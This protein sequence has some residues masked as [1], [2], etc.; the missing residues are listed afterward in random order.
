MDYQKE[1]RFE[2]EFIKNIIDK[3]KSYNFTF[4]NFNK[5]NNYKQLNN[6]DFKFLDIDSNDEINVDEFNEQIIK[7]FGEIKLNDLKLLEKK[8]KS[9]IFDFKIYDLNNDGLIT[10][11]EL[12]ESDFSKK[13]RNDDKVSYNDMKYVKNKDIFNS[14][15]YENCF[16]GICKPT[17]NIINIYLFIRYLVEVE[18]VVIYIN[19][20]EK[21]E[22]ENAIFNNIC[23]KKNICAYH[24]LPIK[25]YNP[26][27]MDILKKF[28]DIIE[29]SIT[30][31]LNVIAH[32]DAGMGRT[33]FMMLCYLIYSEIKKDINLK[34]IYLNEID[35]YLDYI[36]QINEIYKDNKLNGENSYNDIEEDKIEIEI[37]S[38][39][40]II[41]KIK[42]LKIYKLLGDRYTYLASDE[43]FEDIKK[44]IEV[45][46]KTGLLE[47]QNRNLAKKRFELLKE[48]INIKTGG[49]NIKKRKF[50]KKSLKKN[51]NKKIKRRN[52]KTKRRNK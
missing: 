15:K 13:I 46:T 42:Q 48:F 33:G 27:S 23:H 7:F 25:D 36:E 43:L 40:D 5:K 49:K 34:K 38:I 50:K 31:K 26:P 24:H 3:N 20:E 9:N 37:K 12:E 14:F 32:C 6:N 52:K 51:R 10:K 30:N 18:G 39:G 21:S 17:N 44:N 47:E 4:M 8:L 35:I 2:K 29:D 22:L 41:S 19:F 16:K 45:F 1:K 11:N 28:I